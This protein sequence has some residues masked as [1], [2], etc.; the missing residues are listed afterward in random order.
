MDFKYFLILTVLLF[1]AVTGGPVKNEYNFL[2]F[3][4]HWGDILERGSEHLLDGK[5]FSAEVRIN[6]YFSTFKSFICTDF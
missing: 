1:K 6:I 3:H 5:A 4:M 2:Q